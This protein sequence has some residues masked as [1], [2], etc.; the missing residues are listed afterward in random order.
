MFGQEEKNGS[1]LW[2]RGRGEWGPQTGKSLSPSAGRDQGGKAKLLRRRG[3][4]TEHK[5]GW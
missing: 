3:R 4:G 1:I 5:W 2:L